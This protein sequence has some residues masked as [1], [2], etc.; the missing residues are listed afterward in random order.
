MVEKTDEQVNKILEEALKKKKKTP[1]GGDQ[2]PIVPEDVILENIKKKGK[3]K[4]KR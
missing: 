1:R 4:K 3:V 2:R